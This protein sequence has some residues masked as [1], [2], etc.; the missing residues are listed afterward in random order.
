MGSDRRIRE[1]KKKGGNGG[2]GR[3][4][5]RESEKDGARGKEAGRKPR[6]EE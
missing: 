2:S 6:V 4:G 5:C 3:E 1:G